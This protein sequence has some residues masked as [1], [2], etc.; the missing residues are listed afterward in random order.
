M[1]Q[2]TPLLSQL[3][4]QTKSLAVRKLD[5]NYRD[6][7]E[8]DFSWAQREFVAEVERQYNAGKPVRIIT[9]KARQLGISTITE[10]IM[11]LWLFMHPGSNELVVTHETASTMEL[12]GKSKMYWDTWSF[13]PSFSL[14]YN[15]K[16]NLEWADP[17][18]KLR[19]ATAKNVQTGRGATM[20]AVHLSEC[21]FYPDPAT[22]MGG[23]KQ[24]I[25][26]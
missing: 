6:P 14:K 20:H 3:S 23:L 21:A 12:F 9:L 1:L 25:P 26:D 18:S 13:R 24:T 5:L 8:G 15:T 19:V 2:L 22:L 4:I 7:I 16:N 11:F 17:T 10:A